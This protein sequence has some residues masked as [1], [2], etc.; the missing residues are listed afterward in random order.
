MT[1][2]FGKITQGFGYVQQTGGIK[3][4]YTGWEKVVFY[5]FLFVCYY[6]LVSLLGI[7]AE[8]VKNLISEYRL[9]RTH[10]ID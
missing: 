6:I 2:L 4:K 9:R 3:F 7:L 10:D 1:E 8:G 5:G